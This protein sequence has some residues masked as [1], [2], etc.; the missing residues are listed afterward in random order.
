LCIG[1][2]FDLF[3]FVVALCARHILWVASV[4]L[5]VCVFA[6]VCVRVRVRV[7]V[8]ARAVGTQFFKRNY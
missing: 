5:C 1:L 4:C 3:H 2:L 6:F 8:R 7:Y